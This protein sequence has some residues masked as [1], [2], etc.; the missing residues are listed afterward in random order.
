MRI[1]RPAGVDVSRVKRSVKRL[2]VVVVVVVA[3]KTATACVRSWRPPFY[4]YLLS[5]PSRFGPAR[6]PL[7]PSPAGRRVARMSPVMS[8]SSID[9]HKFVAVVG[10]GDDGDDD[11]RIRRCLCRI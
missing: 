1:D 7:R 5:A 3:D 8:A 11:R 6:P 4:A 2:V 10:R 9:Q